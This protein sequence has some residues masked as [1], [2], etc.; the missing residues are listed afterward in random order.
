MMSGLLLDSSF[1]TKSG[2][3]NLH[4]CSSSLLNTSLLEE[5]TLKNE[6]RIEA[7]AIKFS[8]ISEGICSHKP[9]LLATL[10]FNSSPSLDA[11]S[12]VI[13]LFFNISSNLLNASSLLR[14]L[15]NDSLATSD[16]F[17]HEK[18]SI[19]AL[20]ES[21]S[22]AITLAIYNSPLCSSSNFLSN[23]T[24]LANALLITSAQ[25]ISGCLSNLAFNSSGID[26]VNVAI[27]LPP[28]NL[29]NSINTQK[30]VNIYKTFGLDD[31]S[32]FVGNSSY[33][34]SKDGERSRSVLGQNLELAGSGISELMGL[35]F[36][37]KIW[38]RLGR[39]FQN[40]RWRKMRV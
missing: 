23:S 9:C 13:S 40:W 7:S 38:M 18:C 29:D 4:S 10:F 35:E 5:L 37:N 26:T 30:S 39:D 36:Q 27:L 14:L 32:A 12:S 19:S 1:D 3:D 22:D 20:R 25:F 24:L 11:N 28:Y 8:G 16:Q 17:T 2:E 34:V 33:Y 21:G 31:Y 6:N 15:R